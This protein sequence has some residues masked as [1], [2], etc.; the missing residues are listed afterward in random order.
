M[1]AMRA[2]GAT[3]PVS[4][5]DPFAVALIV[6]AVLGLVSLAGARVQAQAMDEGA[7][8]LG[9][10]GLVAAVSFVRSGAVAVPRFRLGIAWT[11]FLAWALVCAALSGRVWA[12]LV[13]EVTNLLGWCSLAA[14][15]AVVMA[16][17]SRATSVRGLLAFI[18]PIVVFGQTA[19]TLVQLAL[20]T[21]PRGSLPN[22]TYLGE[23]VLLLLP[24]VLEDDGGKDVIGRPQRVAL[25][26]SAVVTLAAA[27][28]R[29]AAIAG[30][31][32]LV[33]ALVTRR[34]VTMRFRVLVAAGLVVAVAVGGLVFARAEVLGSLGADTLGERPQMWR[35]VALAVAARPL[36]GYG[37][38]GFV[39]GGVAVTTPELARREPVLVYRPGAVDPHDVLA[40]VAVSTGAIGLALFV[41]ALAEI[42][43]AWRRGTK[44]GVRVGPAAW[45]VGTTAM[46]L[47][48]APLAIQVVPLMG[49]VLGVSLAPAARG[50]VV[51][52]SARG[53]SAARFAGP[54]AVGFAALVLALN[55]GT[56]LPLEVHDAQVSPRLVRFAQA[57]TDV[58]RFD[59]HLA[60]LASLHWG[61]VAASDRGVAATQP[62]LAAIERAVAVDSRDP[63]VA[64]E[65]ARTLRFYGADTATVER[66][67]LAAFERWELY[68]LA[69]A[70]YAILLAEAGRDAEA[71]EQIEI[72]KLVEDRDADRRD[73]IA[74]AEAE[75]GR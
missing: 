59:P 35:A 13:G 68:P 60:H 33:W 22:S 2:Q 54:V 42:G 73:A 28:S 1:C 18:A 62:D 55:A 21:T 6:F 40:W 75:L 8:V 16:A 39:A 50:S 23:A 65:Y 52:A 19:A 24:F 61:W 58:W 72:A 66:A 57:A 32:W 34:D 49:L 20:G 48:T 4:G 47:L 3:R 36:L 38:D 7:V 74:A 67:F 51:P 37:P 56:R 29:V 53:L 44:D 11:A 63:F 27:G 14:L 70:E 41:W 64:L 10:A 9:L 30:V 12:S 69:R 5:R 17:S 45:A 43:L 26:V 46:V 71:R 31:V 15:T 25:A